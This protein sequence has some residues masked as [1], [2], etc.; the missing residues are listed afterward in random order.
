VCLATFVR[1][2]QRSRQP[3]VPLDIF[4]HR[5]RVGGDIVAGLGGA[6]VAAEVLVVS[7]YC[8]EVLG[9]S[10][11]AAGL[12]AVPQGVGGILRGF[13]GPRML[14]RVGLRRFLVGNCLLA[15]TGLAVLFRFPVTS[16]YPLLGLVFI[17][18][19]FGTTNVVFGATVASSSGVADAEQ[20]LAGAVL[21][22]SRQIGS[23][24]GVAVLLSV[25]TS[26]TT[27]SG[28]GAAGGYRTALLW[29][30]AIAGTAALA[31]LLVT[32]DRPDPGPKTG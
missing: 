18:I 10:A 32:P 3:L 16:R 13:V 21:N 19:G 20:G 9:Y 23:A 2:E 5:V 12:V 28:A 30:T 26:T 4:R 15:V 29:A 22:A 17:A 1:H 25:A 31:S 27:G 7:L 24:V 11:L 14:D 8:Q 6:W